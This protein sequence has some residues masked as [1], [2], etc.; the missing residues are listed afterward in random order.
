MIKLS[1]PQKEQLTGVGVA[2]IALMGV[3][4]YFG[5]RAKQ[6]ELSKSERS[7]AQMRDTLK[8]AEGTMRQGE[9]ISDKLQA[10][11][12]A[13]DKREALLA[14]DR[15]SYAWIISTITP[16]LQAR[17]GVSIY[18]YSQPETSELGVLPDFPY[19]WAT[20]HL[21]GTGYYHDFGKFFADLENNFPCFR[22][23]NLEMGVGAGA[24]VQP[25]K[26]NVAFDL[27]VPVKPSDTK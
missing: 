8:R 20:F 2:T 14:P 22:V 17:K 27:V 12:Q 7:T 5:V 1:K 9:D 13:L 4:W 26:L 25:E 11:S 19:K 24:G 6:A 15:D 18:H 21:E 10:Q 23:Q 16:F 3:L